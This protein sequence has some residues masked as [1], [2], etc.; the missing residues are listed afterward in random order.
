MP[1]DIGPLYILPGFSAQPRY[2]DHLEQTRVAAVK[3]FDA[4][5]GFEVNVKRHIYN[6]DY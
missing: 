5:D 1:G 4:A 3:Q 2:T 6:I